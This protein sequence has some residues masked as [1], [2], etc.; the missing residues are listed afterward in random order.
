MILSKTL[1]MI[2]LLLFVTQ[3]PQDQDSIYS[4]SASTVTTRQP[5]NIR[6]VPTLYFGDP[7]A[8]TKANHPYPFA[9]I[10]TDDRGRWLRIQ[11]EDGQYGW[12][13]EFASGVDLQNTESNKLPDIHIFDILMGSETQPIPL[14]D[15]VS[16]LASPESNILQLQNPAL[17]EHLHNL[18]SIPLDYNNL[19]V[20]PFPVK[21]MST[22]I[23]GI[24]WQIAT[25]DLKPIVHHEGLI[26]TLGTN[27]EERVTFLQ[28][29][30]ND[31]VY[32]VIN[33]VPVVKGLYPLW[34]TA[35]NRYEYWHQNILLATY[36][37]ATKEFLEIRSGVFLPSS[38]FIG[39]GELTG[40]ALGYPADS[41]YF[42]YGYELFDLGNIGYQI[43]QS[44]IVEQIQIFREQTIPIILSNAP[45]YQTLADAFDGS[46]PYKINTQDWSTV[47]L[48]Q[49]FADWQFP[50][51]ITSIMPAPGSIET[52]IGRLAQM[53]NNGH[54]STTSKG[55]EI[56]TSE[57]EEITL[58]NTD[59]LIP[60]LAQY[61]V[62][63]TPDDVIEHLFSAFIMD[64]SLS[65]A[66]RFMLLS[67]IEAASPQS[68]IINVDGDSMFTHA[69]F[70][71]IELDR[72]GLWASLY[73]NVPE[74]V[75]G[76]LLHELGG[77]GDELWGDTAICYGD[78][79]DRRARIEPIPYMVEMNDV[80]VLGQNPNPVPLRKDY[81]TLASTIKIFLALSDSSYPTNCDPR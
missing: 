78:I 76:F 24:T 48:Q 67:G 2:V 30:W 50:A 77:H 81:T 74:Q 9:G 18:V 56:W 16:W 29:S 63:V 36:S 46:D 27:T 41:R 51:P 49:Q 70:S 6:A 68:V 22:G 40:T 31:V 55:L 54:W 10:W 39:H 75:R 26:Y 4:S 79:G 38:H 65:D 15:L 69:D 35:N 62:V 3:S 71:Y 47:A 23:D 34:N 42:V 28:L 52:S 73:Y 44:H 25:S 58:M 13:A 20:A 12:I 5:I 32:P 66:Q 21:E 59:Q 8:T 80:F 45:E 1:L 72:S 64:D 11:L 57:Q 17:F 14:N 43:L 19:L 53:I 7:I 61:D 60:F 37:P 33:D